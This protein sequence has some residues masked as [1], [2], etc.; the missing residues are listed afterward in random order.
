MMATTQMIGVFCA[1]LTGKNLNVLGGYSADICGQQYPQLKGHCLDLQSN[2]YV[3]GLTNVGFII[4]AAAAA[5]AASTFGAEVPIYWREAAAALHTPSYYVAKVVADI[6][7]CFC[8]GMM[9]WAG[10]ASSF[11]SPMKPGQL[12]A[13]FLLLEIFGYLSGYLLSFLLP[14]SV[15]GLAGVGWA[16]FWA[17]LYSGTSARLASDYRDSRWVWALSLPRWVNEGWFYAS[18]VRPYVKVRYSGG[19]L[20]GD[21]LFDFGRQKRLYLFFLNFNQAFWYGLL[22]CAV[23]FLLNLIIITSTKLDKKK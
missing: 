6:P 15:C 22:V 10:F 1:A 18:T 2:S 3:S 17:L 4:V 11:E 23:L 7:M 13:G 12:F 14:Y 9:A 21:S 20:N 16:V 8:S 5:V 19:P